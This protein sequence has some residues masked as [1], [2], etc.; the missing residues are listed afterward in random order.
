MKAKNRVASERVVMRRK[1]R[2]EEE[3]P[4]PN[5]IFCTGDAN[6]LRMHPNDRR[7]TVVRMAD[8]NVKLNKSVRNLK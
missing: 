8:K 7:F 1:M 3:V 5:C 2:E 4:T 6:A